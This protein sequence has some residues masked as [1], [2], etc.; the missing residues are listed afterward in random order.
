[1]AKSE[2]EQRMAERRARVEAA[3]AKTE[4]ELAAADT[5]PEADI[6]DYWKLPKTGA[7]TT[8]LNSAWTWTLIVYVAIMAIA[9]LSIA[10]NN[11]QILDQQGNNARMVIAVALLYPAWRI[12]SMISKFMKKRG[13]GAGFSLLGGVKS[14]SS[15]GPRSRKAARPGSVEARMAERQ[16]RVEKARRDGKI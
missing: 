14:L 6:T 11:L 5:E 3:K 10:Q 9:L 1:M 8:I 16:E 13:I 7:A 15:P 4:P 2:L 12:A